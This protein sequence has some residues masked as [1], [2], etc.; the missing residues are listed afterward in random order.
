MSW[1]LPTDQVVLRVYDLKVH[2]PTKPQQMAMGTVLLENEDDASLSF[3]YNCHEVKI[4][5]SKGKGFNPNKPVRSFPMPFD[6][7]DCYATE[8]DWQLFI[9]GAE[10]RHIRKR[11]EPATC[12]FCLHNLEGIHTVSPPFRFK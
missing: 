3:L 8:H 10:G 4:W 7:R 9:S 6:F 5:F 12:Y 11:C 2:D 1:F